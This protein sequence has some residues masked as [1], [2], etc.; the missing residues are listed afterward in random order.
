MMIFILEVIDFCNYIF[1]LMG[2]KAL[3]RIITAATVVRVTHGAT[4]VA[5]MASSVYTM[6]KK[7]KLS[8][9]WKQH[10]PEF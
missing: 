8:K 9:L 1:I 4:S 5:S 2:A 7:N 6:H 3:E 10:E